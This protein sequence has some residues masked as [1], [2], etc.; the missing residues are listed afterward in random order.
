MIQPHHCFTVKSNGG[1]LNVIIMDFSVSLPGN[2]IH[3]PI[4]GIWDTGATSTV[5]TQNVV[6]ALGLFPTGKTLVN[7]AS[8]L[9]K[10]TNTYLIDVYLKPDVLVRNVKVTLGT[11]T[12]GV[13]SLIGMDIIMLGD[14]SITNYQGSTCMSF[15]LPS[16]HE[17]D[18]VKEAKKEQRTRN[19][20]RPIQKGKRR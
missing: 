13:D 12:G 4:K 20:Y 2:S 3:M 11:L 18:Y 15:R 14:F 5:I 8:E 9:N 16:Q 7:T 6:N 19:L 10:T 1:L 17:V